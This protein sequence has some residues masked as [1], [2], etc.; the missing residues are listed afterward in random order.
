MLSCFRTI[1]ESLI[2]RS[3]LD[4]T[5]AVDRI[6]ILA[7][8]LSVPPRRALPYLSTNTVEIFGPQGSLA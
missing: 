5:G 4:Q 1:S 2:A 7:G 6:R 8:R 3:N